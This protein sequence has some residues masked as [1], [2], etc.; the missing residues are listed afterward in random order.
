[1][2]GNSLNAFRAV[3][4]NHIECL[5]KMNQNDLEESDNYGQRP[6]HIACKLGNLQCVDYIIRKA[7]NT[8]DLVSHYG[9]NP[10]LVAIAMGKEKCVQ[11]LLQGNYKKAL[12]R[13]LHRDLN[14]TSSLMAAVARNDND[15]AFWLLKRFGKTLAICP[16]NYKML[17]LHLAASRGNIE[18]IRIVTKYDNRMTNEKDIFGLTPVFYATQGGHLECLQY[19]VEK[20]RADISLVTQKGQSLLQIACLGGHLNI[21]QWLL[22]RS[23]PTAVLWTTKDNVNSLHCAAYQ[24]NVEILKLLLNNFPKRNRREALHIRDFYGNTPLHLSALKNNIE[25]VQYLVMMNYWKKEWLPLL[26][27]TASYCTAWNLRIMQQTPSFGS[28]FQ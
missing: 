26:S 18:F 7:P 16:N 22:R 13:A 25:A 27:T 6:L 20:C 10:L 12:T 14:G 19:L 15:L 1:M 11:R 24:G 8:A 3:R 23:S 2:L 4:L 9:E 21:V 5:M 17:P 28:L